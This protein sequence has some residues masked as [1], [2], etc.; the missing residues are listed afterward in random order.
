MADTL[1][2][3]TTIKSLSINL[4]KTS[5]YHVHSVEII[6]PELSAGQY[7]F[8]FSADPSF[9]YSENAVAFDL[10]QYRTLVL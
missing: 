9:N 1:Q 3:F 5:D 4:P 6:L 2:Q 7:I 10:N 8:L